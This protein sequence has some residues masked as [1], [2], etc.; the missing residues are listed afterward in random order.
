MSRLQIA[1]FGL[2]DLFVRIKMTTTMKV[3]FQIVYLSFHII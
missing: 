1:F 3:N 2:I